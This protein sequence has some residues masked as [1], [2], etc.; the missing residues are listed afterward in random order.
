MAGEVGAT[1]TAHR[2]HGPVAPC[3]GAVAV[4][5]PGFWSQPAEPCL[6]SQCFTSQRAA[7]LARPPAPRET[8]AQTVFKDAARNYPWLP[9]NST[10]LNDKQ[11]LGGEAGPPELLQEAPHGHLR[12]TSAPVPLTSAAS[13]L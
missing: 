7:A 2:W 5:I 4:F 6:E 3:R 12:G 8:H 13:C 9:A 10:H 11:T 1:R